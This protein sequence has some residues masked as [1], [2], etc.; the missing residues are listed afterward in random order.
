MKIEIIEKRCYV[1]NQQFLLIISS[2]PTLANIFC[3]RIKESAYFAPI[4]AGIK[5]YSYAEE[6]LLRP[7]PSRRN[8]LTHYLRL[9]CS[10][11]PL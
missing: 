6:S 1:Y 5:R 10:I 7:L 3:L 11:I 8:V 4:H 9:T 2:L